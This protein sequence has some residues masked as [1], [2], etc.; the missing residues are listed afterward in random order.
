[1]KPGFFYN[2]YIWVILP[3]IRQSAVPT[4]HA[5]SRSCHNLIAPAHLSCIPFYADTDVTRA[6]VKEIKTRETFA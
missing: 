5:A 4:H 1:M 6:R 2:K 3:M